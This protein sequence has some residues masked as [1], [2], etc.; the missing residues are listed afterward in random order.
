MKMLSEK[1]VLK[2]IKVADNASKNSD[3]KRQRLGSVMVYRGKPLV[4]ACNSS[5]TSPMQKE[6]NKLRFYADCKCNGSIHSEMACLLKTK[7]LEIDWSKVRIVVS[8]K[9]EDGKYGMARPCAACMQALKDRGIKHIY[10]TIDND[11]WGYEKIR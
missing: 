2:Y 3:F 9:T 4:S 5:K 11:S 6:Y 7:Y 1:K 8:R 10:Y